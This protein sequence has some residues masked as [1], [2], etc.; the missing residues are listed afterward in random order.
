[1]PFTTKDIIDP[2]NNPSVVILN[3]VT[4]PVDV[5]IGID[6][7][8]VIAESKIL[9]GVVVFERI[10]RKPFEI[11]FE[12]T[13]REKDVAG[14]YIFP[15]ST[16]EILI[17]S[18]WRPD[19][20]IPVVNTYLNNS[21]NV[22]WV[23]IKPITFTTIRGNTNVIASIKCTESPDNNANYGTTLIIP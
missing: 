13:C 2:S 21:L 3:K 8:K 9:D 6:G 19:Q 5:I 10:S 17:D 11:N 12:F 15:Q 18:V 16:I 20:V 23:V 22:F 7:D 14:N 4:L 1:M